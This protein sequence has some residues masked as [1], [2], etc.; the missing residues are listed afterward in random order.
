[1]TVLYRIY[2]ATYHLKD[3]ESGVRIQTKK[4][5]LFYNLTKTQEKLVIDYHPTTN[6]KPAGHTYNSS[7][8]DFLHSL[9]LL[10]AEQKRKQQ[11][12]KNQT[13]F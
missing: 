4:S 11:K 12:E 10:L 2:D 3:E 13:E 6:L 8:N 5:W 7:H 1:M 9:V